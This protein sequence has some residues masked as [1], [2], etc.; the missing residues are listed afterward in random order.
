[1]LFDD[2]DKMP[3]AERQAFWP[4]LSGKVHHRGGR[5]LRPTAA[6]TYNPRAAQNGS[7]LLPSGWARRS[8]R[9][10]A[11]YARSGRGELRRTIEAYY[12]PDNADQ[13]GRDR[14]DLAAL[15]PPVS[16]LDPDA[17]H[18]LESTA[19]MLVDPEGAWPKTGLELAALGRLA[20]LGD[21]DHIRATVHTVV[22]YLMVASTAPGLV[23]PDWPALTADVR[24]WEATTGRGDLA[25]AL[26]A[27]QAARAAQ[28]AETRTRRLGRERLDSFSALRRL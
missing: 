8:V 25:D 22:D 3:A 27:Y 2:V 15:R 19:S 16:C 14:L 17:L 5:Q 13:R 28:A 10:A 20:L 7:Q 18:I 11:D 26:S 9:L 12:R 1:V 24:K 6:V 4:Y 23:R 21:G